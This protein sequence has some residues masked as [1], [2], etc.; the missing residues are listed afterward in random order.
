M[1]R[2]KIVFIIT[3]L[4]LGGA[5]KSVLY[6]AENL[7]KNKFETFLLC[8]EG[9]YFD[10]YARQRIKNIFFIKNL[11][12]QIRPFKD[13]FAFL[14]I[15]TILRNIRPDI[16]HTNSSKAGILG[17]AAA[18]LI[19]KRPKIVHTAH[20]FGFNDRQNYL[21]R[22]FYIFLER[23]FARFTDKIIFVSLRDLKT[24]LKLKIARAEKC[25]LLRAGVELKTKGNF[26]D[27]SRARKIKSLGLNE[28]A[29]IILSVANLKPQ[30]NPL[31]MVRAA[32]IVCEKIPN[33]VFLYLGTGELEKRAKNLIAQNNLQ[34][35]F[36]LLGHRDDT[37]ELLATADVFA[38]SS[39]WEGLPMALVEALSMELP[40]VCYDAG[41]IS[42]LLQDGKNG[43]LIERG[44][45]EALADAILKILDG[46][47]K[48]DCS[49]VDLQE[50]DIKEMLKKQEELYE[51]V[52]NDRNKDT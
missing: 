45:F 30:K 14:E 35:N 19:C 15:L 34:N 41:G 49:V 2:T 26:R 12:R 22:N 32:K 21:I 16:I 33:A 42:E 47:F 40:A 50:F 10:E 23:I 28:N 43:F 27:F 38:L 20:G 8:G 48:F 18:K 44:N 52:T 1:D 17:R 36:K 31:D 29:K 7:D 5:Q 11:Q 3:K 24:A 25:R 6:S 37:A 4:E 51:F 39:L 9:G 46:S 13:F